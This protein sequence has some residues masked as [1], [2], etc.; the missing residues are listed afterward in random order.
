MSNEVK[1][2]LDFKTPPEVTDKEAYQRYLKLKAHPILNG[3]KLMPLSD[4]TM[5]NLGLPLPKLKERIKLL[6]EEEQARVMARKKVFSEIHCKANAWKQKAYKIEGTGGHNAI[7]DGKSAEMI[8]LF[9]RMYTVK[10]VHKVCVQDWKLD[11]AVSTVES[12]RKKHQQVI[13]QKI[14]EFKR[15]YSDIRLS[16]KKSRLEELVWMY[17]QRKGIYELSKK[18][19]DYDLMLKTLEQIRKEAEGDSLRLHGKLEIDQELTIQQH[20]RT[21]VFKTLNI[22]QIILGRIS[23]KMG[24]HPLLLQKTIMDSYYQKYFNAQQFDENPGSP[25]METYDFNRIGSLVAASDE[26][27]KRFLEAQVV[28]SKVHDEPKVEQVKNAL[29]TKLLSVSQNINNVRNANTKSE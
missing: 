24:L 2:E 11:I 29:L 16:V 17:G 12:F 20:I 10:E 7:L 23:S 3:K 19:E 26:S 27:N 22:K 15:D 14:E 13:L 6:E 5:L 1:K 18:K 25:T 21:E 28:S 4:G 9:G 8:D